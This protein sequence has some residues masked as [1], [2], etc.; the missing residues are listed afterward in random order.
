MLLARS[1]E[2][3]DAAHQAA[4]LESSNPRNVPLYERFG[5]QVVGTIQA[6]SSPPI[7]PML[8]AAR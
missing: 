8:R 2:A 4:Y 5:F 1:L 6:G 3:V 7:Y